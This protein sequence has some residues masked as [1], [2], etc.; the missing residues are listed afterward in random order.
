MGTVRFKTI[1][2]QSTDQDEHSYGPLQILDQNDLKPVKPR[3][4]HDA[5]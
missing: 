1:S 4:L 5:T 3:H 2:R